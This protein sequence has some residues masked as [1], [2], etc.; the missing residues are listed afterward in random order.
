VEKGK[1][2][3]GGEGGKRKTPSLHKLDLKKKEKKK[4]RG[5]KLERGGGT[6]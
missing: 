3:T 6:S 2:N 5:G 1:E 4:K